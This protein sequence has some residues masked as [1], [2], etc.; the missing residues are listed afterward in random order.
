MTVLTCMLNVKVTNGIKLIQRSQDW[1]HTVRV[2]VFFI[3]IP[4][5]RNQITHRKVF[6]ELIVLIV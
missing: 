4:L 5:K 1:M 2:L 3:M 6:S